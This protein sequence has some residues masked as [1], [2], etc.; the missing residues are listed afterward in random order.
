MRILIVVMFAVGGAFLLFA[1]RGASSTGG[2]VVKGGLTTTEEPRTPALR[3]TIAAPTPTKINQPVAI[4]PAP[5]P[6]PTQLVATPTA[7]QQARL[8]A[9][10]SIEFFTF[11]GRTD[12]GGI[13]L[14]Q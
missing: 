5:E 9:D 10:P 3:P 2:N 1:K 13:R 6:A 12:V 4:T 14:R 11:A 8:D 7:E